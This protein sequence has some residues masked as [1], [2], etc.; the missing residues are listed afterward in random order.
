LYE[1]LCQTVGEQEINNKSSELNEQ[2]MIRICGD[3]LE[4]QRITQK[5]RSIHTLLV[6]IDLG[7]S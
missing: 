1:Y 5:N 3:K 6:E 4:T 2:S 7:V